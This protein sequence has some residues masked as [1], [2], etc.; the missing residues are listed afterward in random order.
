MSLPSLEEAS[1]LPAE[2]L[3]QPEPLDRRSSAG[4]VLGGKTGYF[5]PFLSLGEYYTDNLFN[6]SDG[7]VDEFI[8]LITPGIWMS[9]PASRQQLLRVRTM[10]TAPGGLAVSRFQVEAERRLQAYGLFR[11]E[12]RE[13]A[14][15]PEEETESHHAEG[16]LQYNFRGGLSLEV[17]DIYEIDQDAYSTGLSRQLDEFRSNF[18]N[19]LAAYQITPKILLRA[20]YSLYSL[21]Y[22]EERNDFR[23]RDD[24][25]VS[26][27]AFYRVLPKTAV[28]LQYEYLDVDYDRD[29]QS[30]SKEHH[31]F[32][33][34]Q[35]NSGAK[36]RARLKLGY[37]MKDFDQEI[38]DREDLIGEFQIDYR[39]S[40]KTSLYLLALRRIDETDIQGGGTIL[41]HRAGIGYNQ[42][43]APR[44][45]GSVDLSYVQEDY[46]ES[47]TFGGVTN[48][49]EDKY[50]SA[51]LSLGYSFRRWLNLSAAYTYVDRNSNFEI[52][53]YTNNTIFLSLT[54][55]L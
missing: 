47:I 12:F 5:H 40:P 49:R 44:I 31:F 13:H 55:A 33:G 19:F 11:S 4:A 27:Y 23:D 32:G 45:T 20:D 29:L 28:F 42:R 48:D 24:Q 46:Q 1:P 21:N 14:N 18:F 41:T 37:G 17:M 38:D 39:Y 51:S 50:V 10:N 8:T 35:W 30:D 3:Y 53:D 22:D 9:F 6:T 16:F 34:L 25:V 43:L 7:E 36:S 2:A 15:F 26:T 54:A 52:F